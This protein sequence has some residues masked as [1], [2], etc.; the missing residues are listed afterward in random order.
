[1]EQK[2]I[3]LSNGLILLQLV[4]ALLRHNPARSMELFP[5]I[6]E[7]LRTPI[8]ALESVALDALELFAEYGITS[9][10]LA[11][12]YRTWVSHLLTLPTHRDTL[13]LTCWLLFGTW[14]QPGDDLLRDLER[15]LETATAQ[16]PEDPVSK[17]P[18]DYRIAIFSF[19][20]AGAKRASDLLLMRNAHLKIDICTEKDLNELAKALARNANLVVIVTTCI[21]HALTYGISPYLATSPVYPMSRGS[22]SI[23]R[24]I[25][26]HLRKLS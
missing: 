22:T 25:E 14:I 23:V 11:T 24:A 7:W 2:E 17:L 3:N 19:D 13:C 10:L 8:A 18:V 16:A 12:W 21:S 9:T 20:A 6:A 15:A 1:L 26:D 4:D 5:H